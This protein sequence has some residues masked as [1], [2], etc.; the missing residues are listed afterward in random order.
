MHTGSVCLEPSGRCVWLS[1]VMSTANSL[2]QQDF[3]VQVK[4]AFRVIRGQE[5]D[6]YAQITSSEKLHGFSRR[7]VHVREG[8]ECRSRR[9][10]RGKSHVL[11][12]AYA[13]IAVSA[14]REQNG[15][16]D[17]PSKARLQA[18]LADKLIAVFRPD[19]LGHLVRRQRGR[20]KC[21]LSYAF[22]ESDLDLEF[23][24]STVAK[25]EVTIETTP[26]ARCKSSD[27]PPDGA[28]C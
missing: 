4:V 28:N 18:A 27:L 13:A 22:D 23:T 25:T 24:F 20:S 15:G 5:C 14:A 26:S 3:R 9:E 21:S 16:T 17:L 6:Y 12:A 8:P 19:G 2:R 1:E 7:R 11:K 10:W